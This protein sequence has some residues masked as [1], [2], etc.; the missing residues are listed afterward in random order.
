MSELSIALAKV[1]TTKGKLPKVEAQVKKHGPWTNFVLVLSAVYGPRLVML[2]KLFDRER[3]RK[4]VV[5]IHA[6][7]R[8]TEPESIPE[9]GELAN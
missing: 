1:I 6:R 2:W 7:E 8:S 4:P 5:V 9:P 3:K